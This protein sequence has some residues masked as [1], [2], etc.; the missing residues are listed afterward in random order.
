MTEPIHIP[1]LTD[2]A[3]D[4]VLLG[5]NDHSRIVKTIA[6]HE[7]LRRARKP[8]LALIERMESHQSTP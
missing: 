2:S 7:M 3:L 8:L 4:E 1:S 6:L 5:V